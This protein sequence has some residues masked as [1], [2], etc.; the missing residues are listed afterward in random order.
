M[1]ALTSARSTKRQISSES[2]LISGMSIPV[3]ASTKCIQ[4][5]IAVLNAGYVAPGTAA[6]GL[7][8]IGMFEDTADNSSGADGAIN[9]RVRRGTFKFANSAAGDA[10]AQANVGG[11]CYIVNDQTV[12]LTDG[13]GTRSFAGAV[14]Q[15]DSDGVWVEI[16]GVVVNAPGLQFPVGTVSIAVDLPSLANAQTIQT[17]LGFAG[18]IKSVSFVVSKPAITAAKAATLSAQIAATPCTGGAIALTS[19][20]CTPQGAEIAGSAVTALNT[21]TAAQAVGAV[22]SAVTTFVEGQGTLII[23]LG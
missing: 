5:G 15:V 23:H 6:L 9:A 13:N 8:A 3:K 18:R 19:A 21:F 17:V 1:A 10:I 16:G 2:P 11:P 22:V 7:I 20:N 4:G 12:A 14:I